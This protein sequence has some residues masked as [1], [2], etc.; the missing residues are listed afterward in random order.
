MDTKTLA[1]MKD[2]IKTIP[3]LSS[4]LK[5]TNNAETFLRVDTPPL[6][7][8]ETE[9]IPLFPRDRSIGGN[10]PWAD[11]TMIPKSFFDISKMIPK[12]EEPID[13]DSY[14]QHMVIVDGWGEF[15]PQQI[16]ETTTEG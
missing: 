10:V 9:F 12:N 2:L 8:I 3:A 1:S 7:L 5:P 13:E 14:M 16:Y 4:S 11:N 6:H 15:L